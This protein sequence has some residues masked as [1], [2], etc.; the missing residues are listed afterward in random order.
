MQHILS[1][2]FDLSWQ[3]RFRP[4]RRHRPATCYDS[5]QSRIEQGVRPLAPAEEAVP[6][7]TLTIDELRAAHGGDRAAL[8]RLFERLAPPLQRWARGRLPGWARGMVSTVDIVQDTL[9]STYLAIDKI[10]D[11]SDLAIHAYLRTALKHRLIDQLRRVQR[12]PVFEEMN[13][14][15]GS[16]V[17]SPLDQ[18]VGHE[19]LTRYET[20]LAQLPATDREAVIARVELGLSY[21]E[22]A[23][24]VDKSSPDAAR[25]AVSR[26][27]LRLAEA[28][29]HG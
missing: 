26:A 21:Q 8:N 4:A 27:L 10:D 18:A 17:D 6:A 16:S 24:L 2:D 5:G 11:V 12:R 25:M 9:M 28:M 7:N 23:A 20:A 19:A 3:G 13:R 29:D 15:H 14:S 22:I 1:S